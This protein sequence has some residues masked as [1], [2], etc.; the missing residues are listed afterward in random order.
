MAIRRILQMEIPED[1]AILKSKSSRVTVFDE[2]L[3][4]LADDMIETM[5]V[6]SG[7][8]IAAPQVGVLRRV[9][10]VEESPEFET[11]EDGTRTIVSPGQLLVMVN[12]EIIKHSE[13]DVTRFE[14]CLSLPGRYGDVPRH[15]W[16]TVKYQDLEG[17]EH[18]IRHAPCDTHK[19]GHIVQH[20]IDHLNGIL[21]TE[22]IVDLE[23]LVDL[24]KDDEGKRRRRFLGRRRSANPASGTDSATAE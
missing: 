16:V 2:S 15:A 8:G 7:V 21:F 24:R 9:L 1:L 19:V 4:R 23:T 13:E 3:K 10:I 12:P 22:R 14:G 18:R 6:A 17:H 11:L 5:H 20:E